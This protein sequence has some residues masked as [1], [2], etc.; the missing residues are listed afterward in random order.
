MPLLRSWLKH[1]QETREE[2]GVPGWTVGHVPRFDSS[3]LLKCIPKYI[4]FFFQRSIHLSIYLSILP[5]THVIQAKCSQNINYTLFPK[6]ETLRNFSTW[7][8]KNQLSVKCRKQ[9]NF[10]QNHRINPSSMEMRAFSIIDGGILEQQCMFAV[11]W[12]PVGPPPSVLLPL[13][14]SLSIPAPISLSLWIV[15]VRLKAGCCLPVR[16]HKAPATQIRPT[17]DRY[18]HTHTY[19]QITLNSEANY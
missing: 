8:K 5:S 1:R 6:R 16:P 4:Y 14:L 9:L 18:T 3:E 19:T 10:L 2:R 12:E 17:T 11:F 13:T 7:T 15:A